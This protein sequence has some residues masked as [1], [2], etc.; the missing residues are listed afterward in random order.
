MNLHPIRDP[1]AGEKVVFVQPSFATYVDRTTD[2]ANEVTSDNLARLSRLNFFPGRHLND[3]ALKFE[4]FIRSRR[5]ELRG[6]AVAPGVVRGLEVALLRDAAEPSL[7]IAPGQALAASGQ[8]LV[9]HQRVRVDIGK[10]PVFDPAQEKVLDEFGGLTLVHAGSFAVVLVAVPWPGFREEPPQALR[11]PGHTTE[12]TPVEDDF[13]DEAFVRRTD[14]D[15]ARLMLCLWPTQPP[16]GPVWRNRLA[17]TI[18]LAE[19][20]GQ[21]L[22]WTNLGVPLALIA[23]N[24]ENKPQ[25]LDRHA[26]ARTGGRPLG[27]KFIAEVGEPRIWEAQFHQFCAEI[28]EA[29][30]L[31]PATTSF[32]HLPPIGLLPRPVLTLTSDKTIPRRPVWTVR[33]NFFPNDWLMDVAAVPLE[34]LDALADATRSLERFSLDRKDA[35]RLLLPVPQQF[36]NPDLLKIEVPDA[37]F[38]ESINKF[39]DRRGDNLAKRADLRGR[40]SALNQFATGDPSTYPDP[41]PKQLESPEAPVGTPPGAV[42]QF[43]TFRTIAGG[44]PAYSVKLRADLRKEASD[45]F[46]KRFTDEDRKEFVSLFAACGLSPE[47]KAKLKTLLENT[48]GLDAVTAA[49]TDAT[50]NAAE[51]DELRRELIA[52]IEKQVAIQVEEQAR[53]EE[54]GLE[55]LID[56]LDRKADAADDL[57]ESGFLKVRTD[58]FRLGQLLN[59]NALGTTF[60]ASPSL[61]NILER[62]PARADTVAVNLFASQL[63][64]NLA[65]SAIKGTPATTPAPA[66]RASRAGTA[67]S[68]GAVTM[69]PTAFMDASVIST[70]I[71]P[72]DFAA[73]TALIPTEDH[74]IT[75]STSISTL[76]TN[77]ALSTT[78]RKTL[79]DAKALID[80]LNVDKLKEAGLVGKF[81]DDYVENFNTLSQKQLRKIPLDRLQ[82]ALA[83]TVRR[84]IHDGRLEIFERLTRLDISLGDV[85]TDFVDTPGTPVRPATPPTGGF[86]IERLR[87]QTL[88]ARRQFETISEVVEGKSV[89]DADES[90]HFSSG[91]NYADMTMAALR[92]VEARI[93]QYR[94]F[95]NYCRTMLAQVEDLMAQVSSA[96]AIAESELEE[97]RHDVATAQALLREEEA[98]L[99][100]IND[101]REQILQQQVPF[102]VFHRPRATLPSQPTP[103]RVLEPALA[104]DPVPACLNEDLPMP[105][106]F[107]AF[108]DEFRDSPARWFVNVPRW[109]EKVD[110]WEHL[111]TMVERAVSRPVFERSQSLP[112]SAGRFKPALEGMLAVRNQLNRQLQTATSTLA[113]LRLDTLSWLDLRR[114]AHASLTLGQLIDTGPANLSREA[115]T[116]LD[117]LFKIGACLHQGFS[118][119]PALVRLHWAERY[120]QFDGA[121]DFRELSVL[122][123]WDQIEFTLRRELQLETNWVFSR[124]D[125][126]QP[127][128]VELINDLVRAALLLA[129]HSPVDELITGTVM[130]ETRPAP[131]G[132]IRILADP[133]RVRLGMDVVLDSRNGLLRGI[134]EDVSAT[135]VSARVVSS[136]GPSVILPMNTTVRF[137]T[138]RH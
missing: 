70:R 15:G 67:L 27:R 69:R 126:K 135:H 22:P 60:A 16:P 68:A 106:E 124:I 113:T 115:A 54:L 64:A 14:I 110:R 5:L 133:L 20:S 94:D 91:V 46:L 103:T 132:L 12:F 71:T 130:E 33:Q 136:S 59:N 25:W 10:L 3:Q 62:K 29:M 50:L 21:P 107:A 17:W 111:R 129:S 112:L 18:F 74:K 7:E 100:S 1:L 55:K 97:A 65:P 66:I 35:V 99:K 80:S 117:N 101:H 134:V 90:R 56:Y 57:V 2:Q 121:A 123:Q 93:R 104:E 116:E 87:F 137:Q 45:H 31:Q 41:D 108:R 58:I 109:I 47:Q 43:G 127:Q 48:P 19:R 77:T 131:G 125:Q 84:E 79:T 4:Q 81:A 30:P 8:D 49:G 52:Y 138:V 6:Q 85:T 128:A 39:K 13:K 44:P 34:Q 92:A 72:A 82:P 120:S 26:V 73:T 83:P 32:V 51:K 89:V 23:F 9:F 78:D 86:R 24:A 119:V 95:I 28:T 40:Q 105:A 63:I 96:L 61:A 38:E 36:F 37:G 11:S 122:P 118:L 114:E 75:L 102:I 53:V 42:D 98:R 88:I 76:A